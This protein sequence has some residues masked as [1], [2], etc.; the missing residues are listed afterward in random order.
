MKKILIIGDSTIQWIRPYRNHIDD[1]TYVE[2]LRKEG[3][4]I[5]VIS[6]P[7]MTSKEVLNIY[8]NTLG[9]KFYDIYIVSVG[10]N[11]LTPRSYPR[12]MW[13]IY[14]NLLIKES[15]LSKTF[16]IFYRLFTNKFIQKVFSKYRISKPW[17]SLKYF[18]LYLSKFQ[19][20]VIKETDSKIIYLSL[21]MVSTRVSSILYGIEKNIVAYKRVI[22]DLVDNKR[23]YEIDID[24]L[25]EKDIEKY[26]T[27]GIHY[28][29]D[30]HKIIFENLVKM[31]KDTK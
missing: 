21:P 17:I 4:D 7:G 8:W 15:L 24:K 20:L 22:K 9:G 28:T 23:V 3:Y 30:G 16:D 27:E 5:D 25:F 1:F 11:D 10:I 6:M 2:L 12:W 31:I 29:A 18:N 13:K 14:N 19:E 26:N